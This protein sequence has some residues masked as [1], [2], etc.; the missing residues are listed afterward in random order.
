MRKGGGGLQNPQER[1]FIFTKYEKVY[2]VAVRT[3]KIPR[4]GC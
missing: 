1:H 4:Q 2:P 3:K